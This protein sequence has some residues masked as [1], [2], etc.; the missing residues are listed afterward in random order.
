MR[1]GRGLADWGLEGDGRD[2]RG[3]PPPYGSPV[4]RAG[5]GQ[6]SKISAPSRECAILKVRPASR[7]G[8]R[9]S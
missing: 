4:R 2:I 8:V 7:G 6:V 1:R 5:G 9:S 3:L